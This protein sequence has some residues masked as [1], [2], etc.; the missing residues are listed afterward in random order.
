MI[1]DLS[2]RSPLISPKTRSPFPSNQTAIAHHHI[3]HKCDRLF[4]SNQTA[5]A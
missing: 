3:T 4:P 2:Y 1:A 5:I